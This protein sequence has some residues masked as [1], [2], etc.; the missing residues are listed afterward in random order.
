MKDI[1]KSA[2]Y[3]YEIWI[4]NFPESWHPTTLDYFYLFVNR[5]TT[6]SK[7]D[8]GSGWLENNLKEDCPKLN[9]D[10]IK[11]YCDIYIHLKNFKNVYKNQK[12]FLIAIAKESHENNM[13]T[14]RNKY[15]K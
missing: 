2:V 11:K 10:D 4:N 5:I 15:I 7:K 13:K 3:F 12:S 8:R 9:D 1:P 6:F 14:V